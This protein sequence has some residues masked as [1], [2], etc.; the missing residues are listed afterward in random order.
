MITLG[1]GVGGGII[2]NKK[3]FRGENGVAGEIGH[4]TIDYKGD[5]CKCGSIG[6]IETFVGN[7]Y[8]IKRIEKEL[9]S[10][11]DSVIWKLIDDDF[12]N[13]NPKINSNCCRRK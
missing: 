8:L 6:C 1:T 12:N 7:N 5:Q 11:K 13:L 10:H 9:P 4:M 2:M 3:I